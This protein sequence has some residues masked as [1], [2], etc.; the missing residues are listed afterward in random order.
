M[1]LVKKKVEF[2]ECFIMSKVDC[3]FLGNF[4]SNRGKLLMFIMGFYIIISYYG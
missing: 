4:V 1:V 3:E 2:L